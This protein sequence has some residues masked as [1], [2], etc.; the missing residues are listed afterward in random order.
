MA[1]QGVGVEVELRVQGHQVALAVTVERV[2]LDQRG[3]RLHVAGVELA[4]E[5]HGL[6]NRVAFHA[7]GGSDLL[8]LVDGQAGQRVD[9][10]GD[11]LLGVLC[12]TSSMSMPP[13]LDAMKATFAS[14][15]RSP[16]RR[17]TP[18]R[19]RRRLRYRGDAP[20]AFR[21]GLVGLEL[22]AEDGRGFVLTSSMLLATF[23]PPPLATVACMDLGLH[24]PDRATELLGGFDGFLHR[25][26]GDATRHRHAKLAQDLLP[27]YS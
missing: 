12:A 17:R 24:D 14:R 2:D 7:D 20:L 16:G 22:H 25:E 23:T 18:C 3:I 26:G 10:L 9:H 6:I 27:W 13:S 5:V 19:C 11:D 1:E 21:A 4:E 15:G 8:G